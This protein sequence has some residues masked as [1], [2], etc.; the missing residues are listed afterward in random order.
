MSN[1]TAGVGRGQLLHLDEHIAKKKA[2][3]ET[4]KDAFKDYKQVHMN[5]YETCSE[6]NFWLSCMTIDEESKTKPL[7][8]IE[9]LERENIESRPIWKPLHQQPVFKGCEFYSHY[10]DDKK[11]VSEDIFDRGLCPVSY[12]HLDVYKRQGHVR[13]ST[14]GESVPENAQP[15][16]LNYVKG[17]LG[18]AHNGNLINA[19]ELREELEKTGAIF[20]TTIDSEVIA[21]HIARERVNTSSI[22]KARCV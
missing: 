18:L 20:Q 10:E 2:I 19:I 1:I 6:P 21:Y 13:Y 9:A 5:P 14:A 15:L 3:Y 16:V 22:E 11:P 12:T 17:T 7:D 8:I 4:Y